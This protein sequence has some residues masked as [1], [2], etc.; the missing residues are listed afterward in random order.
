[1]DTTD[2]LAL[3]YPECDPP[4]TEDAS[5]IAQFRALAEATDAAVQAYA[6]DLDDTLLSPDAAAMTGGSNTA[7][8]DVIHAITVLQFENTPGMADTLA[9]GIRIPKDG[10]YM[11]GGYVRASISPPTVVNMR[12]EPLVNGDTVSS[13]QGPGFHNV[14]SE[15]VTWTDVLFM[16]EGDLLNVMTHHTGSS[17]TVITYTTRLWALLVL[18]NV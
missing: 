15:D 13:R 11:V 18:A 12:V 8:Q 2:C 17:A 10:W 6:D 7:G 4:L 16:R 9:G 14:S 3:P 1:M 5:D